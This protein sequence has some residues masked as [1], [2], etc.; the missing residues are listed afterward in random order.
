M[1][2]ADPT[3]LRNTDRRMHA[4]WA[5]TAYTY[6]YEPQGPGLVMDQESDPPAGF[7]GRAGR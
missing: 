6:K 4:R 3:C 5:P 7:L 1:L 2:D